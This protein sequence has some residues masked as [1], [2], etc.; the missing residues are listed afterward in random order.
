M[1]L[2]YSCWSS[3]ALFR[4]NMEKKRKNNLPLRHQLKIKHGTHKYNCWS[5]T[6]GFI[7][8]R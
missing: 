6:K 1:L 5:S 2:V 4:Y 8:N 7:G 3:I